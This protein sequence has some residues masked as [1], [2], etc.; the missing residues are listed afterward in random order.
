[1]PSED[2]GRPRKCL[3]KPEAAREGLRRRQRP[4][5]ARCQGEVDLTMEWNGDILQVMDRKTT[6][7][8]LCRAQGR[9]PALA[10]LPVHPQ[11]RATSLRMRTRSSTIV[12][13]AEAGAAIADFH[14]VCDTQCRPPGACWTIRNTTRTRRSS[15]TQADDRQGLRAVDLSR[16][17]GLPR[18]CV[19]RP[20]RASWRPRP[21]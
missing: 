12:L 19:T 2:Q 7:S 3:F 5:P 21:D 15:R 20:G 14:P 4:G 13:D 17:R 10:G 8:V 18:A 6:T 11:G 9:R 16:V 1:M